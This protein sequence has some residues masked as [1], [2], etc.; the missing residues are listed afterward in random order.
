MKKL[1]SFLFLLIMAFA[2]AG[3][4]L[5][6]GGSGSGG[7]NTTI[8]VDFD[9]VFETI[10][11]QI[12]DKNNIL[13]DVYLMRELGDVEITWTSSN[14]DVI[15]NRGTVIRP[16]VDTEVILKCKLHANGKTSEEYTIRVIV[17][18]EEKQTVV[19]LSKI[20]DVIKGEVGK[21][22]KVK[23]TV[24]AFSNINFII[25]DTTGYILSYFEEGLPLP[26]KI[27]D[28]V[29]VNGITS[30]YGGATQ[31]NA[32]SYTY[33]SAETVVWPTPRVLD[34]AAVDGLKK[35][36][37]SI[38]YVTMEGKL[39]KSGQYYNITVEGATIVGSIASPIED[40]SDYLDKNVK[41]TGYFA[42]ISGSKY[43]YLVYTNIEF[44]NNDEP[45]V[46]VDTKT[47][48]EVKALE[49]NSECKIEAT[50]VAISN[51][52]FLLK[53][54]TDM[55]LAYAGATYAKDLHI[56][57]K[58]EL[59]GKLSEYGG[60]KQ[61][62]EPVYTVKGT[63]S[64]TKPNPRVLDKD[65][66]AALE[67]QQT[68]EFIELEA[69]LRKSG[70]YTN[71]EVA[72]VSL[73]GSIIACDTD[74]TEFVD[75]VVKV[76]GYFV[77]VSGSST[78]YA[79]IVLD[80]IALS[81]NQ[82]TPALELSTLAQVKAGTIGQTYLS[83]A[84]VVAVSAQSILLKDETGLMYAYFGNT[85]AKDLVVGDE[86]K[87]QGATSVYNN[88]PQFNRP[89]YE[90]ISTNPATV[91]YPQAKALNA[92]E[93][94]A[95]KAITTAP[96]TEYVKITGL[97][98]KNGNYLNIEFDGTEIQGSIVY[99]AFDSATIDN[100]N[101]EIEGYYLYNSTSNN[102]NYVNIICVT[103]KEV[104]NTN[105]PTPETT[106]VKTVLDGEVGATYK[107]QATIV[108]ISANSFVL[109]DTTGKI[110][111]YFA[112]GCDSTLVVGDV[113]EVS[114]ATSVYG[115]AKQFASPSVAK[116]GH[117][118][119][120][121][122]SPRTLDA[123][124]F[125]NLKQDNVV[126]EYVE[127]S[128]TLKL[129]GNYVNVEVAGSELI[130]S[131]T[132]KDIDFST[133]DN[134]HVKVTGYFTNNSGTQYLTVIVTNIE[135]ENVTGDALFEE[136]KADILSWNNANI[137]TSMTLPTEGEGYTISWKSSNE[138]VF[139]ATGALTSPSEDTVVTMTATLTVGTK[140]E[141][142]T[143]NVNICALSDIPTLLAIPQTG[144]NGTYATKGYVYAKSNTGF[145]IAGEEG[146]I[147]ATT[148]GRVVSNGIY[149]YA[150][151]YK[152][153]FALG[154]EVVVAGELKYYNGILEFVNLKGLEVTSNKKTITEQ[155]YEINAEMVDSLIN[156][157][158]MMIPV[159]VKG[160]LTVSGN[161]TNVSLGGTT[162]LLSIIGASADY[163]DLSGKDV[164]IKGYTIYVSNSKTTKYLNILPT[165]VI[166][167]PN[168]TR[169]SLSLNYMSTDIALDTNPSD[170]SSIVPGT[171]VS[172]TI[173]KLKDCN[174]TAIKFNDE[175]IEY[176]DT[177]IFTI[178][179]DSKLVIE[180]ASQK[181]FE[182]A[183]AADAIPINPTFAYGYYWEGS[184]A[185]D[186][187]VLASIN[188]NGKVVVEFKNIIPS[189]MALF[190]LEDGE[191]EPN[192]EYTNLKRVSYTFRASNNKEVIWEDAGSA[193]SPKDLAFVGKIF[194]LA[195]G[196]FRMS[197]PLHYVKATVS[198]LFENGE[199]LDLM[200]TDNSTNR[201]RAY[202]VAY[203]KDPNLRL[204]K[205]NQFVKV[206]DEIVFTCHIV[207]DRDMGLM[208]D[209]VNVVS[210]NGVELDFTTTYTFNVVNG[211]STDKVIG[212]IGYS[213]TG[214]SFVYANID[215]NTLTF[216][217]T[218]PQDYIYVCE[219]T[220]EEGQTE[221]YDYYRYYRISERV[222]ASGD[223]ILHFN[224]DVDLDRDTKLLTVNADGTWSFHSELV[225]NANIIDP[226]LT[227]T[228]I[229]PFG[230]LN[231]AYAVL[232]AYK[233]ES[234]FSSLTDLSV[235][236]ANG[237]YIVE[238]TLPKEIVDRYTKEY[239]FDVSR[240]GGIAIDYFGT[241][242][243]G[244]ID[245][246]YS[247]HYM[248]SIYYFNSF[249]DSVETEGKGTESSPLTSTDA[250]AVA[251]FLP[252]GIWS[253][254]YFYVEGTISDEVTTEYA[255]FHVG[256]GEN[257]IYVYGCS[258]FDGLYKL[259][260]RYNKVDSTL[261]KTG[262]KVLLYAQI[263]HYV[264]KDGVTTL[265]LR[266]A[267]IIKINDA[268]YEYTVKE[269]P[270]AETSHS[271]TY[272]DPYDSSDALAVAA[273]LDAGETTTE[274][275]YVAGT[276]SDEVTADYA[277]FHIG[278]GDN[279]ILV[280]GC[281]TFDGQYKIGS[282]YAHVAST[283]LK[284]G[285]LVLLQTKIQH[286]VDK[287]GNATLELKDANV[288]LINKA[289]YTYELLQA[290]NEEA[291]HTGTYEDPLDARDAIVL[292]SKLNA[293]TKEINPT[294]FYIKAVVTS[295]P[296]A[297]YC[298]FTFTYGERTILM[299][300]LSQDEDFTQRYGS[301]REIADLPLSIGDEVMVYG[302]LQ[303]Y[304]GKLEVQ[305]AQLI[306]V[307]KA[308]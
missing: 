260:S 224:P 306:S 191:T 21:E 249:L 57:D 53:D 124:A 193:D 209:Y 213:Q 170:V 39:T 295:E 134:K 234:V 168:P 19:E 235:T 11:A 14:T 166:E 236:Y 231:G 262:D 263:H 233:E 283:L 258:T 130:G 22:Y 205:D 126:I 158:F 229:R 50:V 89:T 77:Y 247:D 90:K 230:Y 27:G 216:N 204:S 72:G 174:I 26:V 79:N 132:S 215:F 40:L 242:V 91:E 129:S 71:L 121:Y 98:K 293:E 8:E 58:V 267:R 138:A 24:V 82:D 244:N 239:Y 36:Q 297:D 63:E 51:T 9:E 199:Y 162:N 270:H 257:A 227:I 272:E 248:V 186:E 251:A 23:G 76:Q 299:W 214:E 287:D 61:I 128:G 298:N 195:D 150:S 108:A 73:K 125:T 208:L 114:G 256:E 123:T 12:P 122:P 113:V 238:F 54:S 6:G 226:V 15:T 87:L 197:D 167:D 7:N 151:G 308:N 41:V 68:I 83:K 163:Q 159:A 292:A 290:S 55:I 172:I 2:L 217:F 183:I 118:E 285:D 49:L 17:K 164:I 228:D 48:S 288:I 203:A 32:P 137:Y 16:D 190:E 28:V 222:T 165:E 219:Y 264:S 212:A 252:D 69:V 143:F 46:I 176:S 99:P 147:K 286:Y 207:N 273:F 187:T 304:E 177:L 65:A 42:Y 221:V 101:V 111:A 96:T 74:F 110:L 59:S 64:V 148:D 104:E 200:L 182:L 10:S 157:A 156:D 246:S 210:V 192:A 303:N 173:R 289:E 237:K 135:E 161:Y 284:T 95:L 13:N 34:A 81:E 184:E 274:F 140:T 223:I 33:A 43:A 37:V 47:I 107:L 291:V 56:G 196:F 18:A 116:T 1:L 62:I 206:G 60:L 78:K 253:N 94:E 66:F 97:A 155:Y 88:A 259:G 52:S 115:G 218:T 29:E 102:I 175:L 80:N 271:G 100:K 109:E 120:T 254:D 261:I 232:D 31:F 105:P 4:S 136:I 117:V 220:L 103:Y 300:G 211:I 145:L 119:Y 67:N 180:T 240:K 294:R 44:G 112:T 45:V 243:S 131:L 250:L 70:S 171:Q 181:S 139:S 141:D 194:N 154:D 305:N 85:F 179:K 279:A 86:I 3:C 225:V 301:N 127:F 152:D 188:E 25:K 255:N 302:Y 5:L 153:K 241:L 189:F 133:L 149:V 275:V 201:I 35:D 106:T 185:Y 146:V 160:N 266:D 30:T 282:A 202:N 75:K 169:Y 84:V 142:I 20:A 280:Y 281:S 265:E 198:N 307:V 38:E 245:Y 268:T 92:E 276:I 277:N 296:T 144:L 269:E 178:N 93:I 278:E